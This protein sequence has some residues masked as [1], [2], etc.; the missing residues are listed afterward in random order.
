MKPILHLE[1]ERL[2]LRP[3]SL[4]DVADVQRLAG[5][6]AIADTTLSIPH[7]YKDG[8]AKE[9][10]AK[11]QQDVEEGKRITFAVT[12]KPD[13]ILIGSI[14]LMGIAAGHKA[15]LG[16]WIG[17]S[18]WNQGFCTEACREIL[19][20]AFSDLD[21]FRVHGHHFSRNPASGRVMRKIGMQYEGSMRQHVKKWDQ[22]EDVEFYG[23]LKTDRVTLLMRDESVSK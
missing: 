2:K 3:F 23:I 5:D 1:T 10:I 6:R 8:D 9:W 15:E 16:Y 7:P 13:G 14:S 11:H 21:L 22:F 20:Y 17:R 19:R 18:Y 12:R 4:A